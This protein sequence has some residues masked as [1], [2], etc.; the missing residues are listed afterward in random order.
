M[1]LSGKITEVN[2]RPLRVGLLGASFETENL[3]VAALASGAV[4]AVCHS[5]PNASIFVL[6]YAK[7]PAT[8]AV[9]HPGG[10]AKVD[11]LNIRFSKRFYLRNN[12]AVLILTALLLRFI[13]SR[14]RREQILSRVPVLSAIQGTDV[15][16]S[17]AGGDSFSDIYGLRRLIYVS[18]PQIL[19]LVMGKPL[20]L[21]PQTIGPFESVFAKAIAKCILSRA[22]KV[23]SRDE[24]SLAVV[25]ELIGGAHKE[26]EV[27]YD[28]GFILE[29]RIAEDRIPKFLA[30]WRADDLLV[31]LNISGLLYMG[32]YTRK[33]MF[34]L[35][36]DYRRSIQELIDF[37]VRTL[38]ADVVLVPHVTGWSENGESDAVASREV[39]AQ[40]GKDLQRRIHLLEEDYDQHEIKAIIGRCSFFLGSRMHA[41]IA[42]LSQHVPSIALAYSRKFQGVF[43]T[44]DMEGL[45]I[46]LCQHE[47]NTLLTLVGRVFG[48][49][50]GIR[51]QLETTMP[52][53]KLKVYELFS[54]LNSKSFISK[55][56]FDTEST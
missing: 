50:Q 13:P 17:I 43:A 28:M 9:P 20:L 31:G 8:Y 51:S 33:N 42:A 49:R 23:Y 5:H 45:V 29:P 32:G 26:V 7:E 1:T 24:E 44:I 21:L 36:V 38:G 30:R 47:Y 10:V 54:R 18:L 11:L 14:K 16:G 55:G 34:G 3:G 41:C 37:F 56:T 40:A 15:F 4:A 35:N 46:D 25:K 48:N 53:A 12:I 52:N 19:I 6:D 2:D 27:R 39:Y 22:S